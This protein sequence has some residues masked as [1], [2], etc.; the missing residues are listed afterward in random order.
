LIEENKIRIHHEEND[1]FTLLT[2]KPKELQKFVTKFV[3]SEEA[4]KNGLEVVL[5]RK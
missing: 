1:D 2:A 3:N 4:F 5:Q